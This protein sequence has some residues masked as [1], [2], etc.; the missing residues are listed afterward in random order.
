MKRFYSE[1]TTL[2]RNH[3]IM[4]FCRFLEYESRLKC[5]QFSILEVGCGSARMATTFIRLGAAYQ[6]IDIDGQAISSAQ[7]SG[8]KC[9]RTLSLFDLPESEQHDVVMVSQVLEH[10][11]RPRDFIDRIHRVLSPNGI[12]HL[13][14]PNHRSLSAS[15]NTTLGLSRKRFGAVTL[16]HHQ[17]S[18]SES[19]LRYLLRDQFDV[20]V[21]SIN[22]DEPTW[23]Q[24]ASYHPVHRL[25]Y[26]AC[27]LANRPCMTVA[28]GTR[29]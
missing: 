14:V 15:L 12:I 5:S 8:L 17:F 13:D 25:F 2:Q 16:P 29:K 20:E 24:V 18:Y 11:V 27:D 9:V 3:E 19:T 22:P 28:I 6:G 23:G 10:I 26:A 7:S 4:A 21:F 1:S